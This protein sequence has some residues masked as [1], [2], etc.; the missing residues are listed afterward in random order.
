M[1]SFAFMTNHQQFSL[2]NN[3]ETTRTKLMD[4]LAILF[5]IINSF[6]ANANKSMTQVIVA[7]SNFG[8]LSI[9]IESLVPFIA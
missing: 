9:K 3:R 2:R 8:R 7:S 5:L 6:V 4:F 1:R